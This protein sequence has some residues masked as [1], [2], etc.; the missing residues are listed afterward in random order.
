MKK[1]IIIITILSM[2]LLSQDLLAQCP[3]CKTALSSAR[4]NGS[5]VGS[6]LNNGILYLLALPYTIA[7]IFGIIWYRN[8]R[9]QKRKKLASL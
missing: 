7:A 9:I 4:D 6:S 3:M 1:A 8:A 2:I 5:S